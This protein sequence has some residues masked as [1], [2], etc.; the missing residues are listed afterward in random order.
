M[1]ALPIARDSPRLVVLH[2]RARTELMP[3]TA[4]M[5]LPGGRAPNLCRGEGEIYLPPSRPARLHSLG[6]E[7][8]QGPCARTWAKPV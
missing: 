4:E 7:L 6:A 2:L 3:L 1:V 8:C 5:A